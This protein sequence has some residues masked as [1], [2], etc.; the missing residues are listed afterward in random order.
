M[1]EPVGIETHGGRKEIYSF[2][3]KIKHMGSWEYLWGKDT[4]I[5]PGWISSWK[6]TSPRSIPPP[7]LFKIN[8]VL[9]V[10]HLLLLLFLLLLFCMRGLY[11]MTISLSTPF[12]IFG[13]I[14][15]NILI[16]GYMAFSQKIDIFFSQKLWIWQSH[17]ISWVFK[18]Q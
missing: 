6:V 5:L 2:S 11:F 3:S 18:W 4:S 16:S 1:L 8:Q 7:L 9:Y 14:V 10:L 15:Y 13:L 17:H 12:T